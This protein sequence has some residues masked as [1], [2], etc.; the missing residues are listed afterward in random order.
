MYPSKH[1]LAGALI[2]GFMAW[3]LPGPSR[4]FIGLAVV[5]IFHLIPKGIDSSLEN[6]YGQTVWF[7]SSLVLG[8]IIT[9]TRGTLE[10]ILS[11][12][13]FFVLVAVGYL[14]GLRLAGP[15][16]ESEEIE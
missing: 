15:V 3:V 13:Y 1:G 9:M 4:V 5:L 2:G 8:P 12:F 11:F 10:E 14:L 7:V 16:E 6:K